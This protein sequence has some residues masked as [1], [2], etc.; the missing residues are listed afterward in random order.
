MAQRYMI[1]TY[2]TNYIYILYIYLLYI[3]NTYTHKSYMEGDSFLDVI[4]DHRRENSAPNCSGS[5][6]RPIIHP[7]ESIIT[8]LAIPAASKCK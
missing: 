4:M 6:F 2:S 7:K 1:Y 3:N 8:F 5:R